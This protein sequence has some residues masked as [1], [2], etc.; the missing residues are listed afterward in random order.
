MV[1]DYL[2]K[3]ATCNIC[4]KKKIIVSQRNQIKNSKGDLD[5][6]LECKDCAKYI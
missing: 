2:G 5:I 3:V 4:K 6:Y 1:E